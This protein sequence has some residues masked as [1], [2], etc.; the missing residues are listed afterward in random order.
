[1][2]ILILTDFSEIALNAEK[3]AVHL[4]QDTPT[5]FYIL[6]IGVFNKEKGSK[7][8]QLQK[9]KAI[10]KLYKNTEEIRQKNK[11][12]RFQAIFTEDNVINATRKLVA[13]KNIDLI[14]MGATGRDSEQNPILGNHTYELI[15]KV[16]CNVLAIPE[17][18]DYKQPERIIVPIDYSV[19]L[20]SKIFS[21]LEKHTQIWKPEVKL[22]ELSN[23]SRNLVNAVEA[24]ENISNQLQYSGVDFKILKEKSLPT[25]K[26]ISEIQKRFDM[27]A[28]L[29]K[30][31]SICNRLLHSKHGLFSSLS[32]RLPILVLHD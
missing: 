27:I 17:N 16:K 26:L 24:R 21:F 28:I 29:G 20:N 8:I 12:H 3:Y 4:W 19:S 9:K 11:N 31:L 14:V 5:N 23:S 1:M 13:E 2:N 32:N 10:E 18:C 7:Y 22:M 25:E 6:N 15:K 30:N